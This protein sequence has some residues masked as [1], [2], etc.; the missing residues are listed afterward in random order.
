M[1]PIGIGDDLV[2][3][4]W[5]AG[6]MVQS[7]LPAPPIRCVRHAPRLGRGQIRSGICM[8]LALKVSRPREERA[9]P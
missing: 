3:V 2:G 1:P 5:H 9:R 4:V 8:F 6:K 7:P